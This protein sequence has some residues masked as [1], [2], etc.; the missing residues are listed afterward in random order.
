MQDNKRR[1]VI[2]GGVAAGMKAASRLRRLDPELEITVLERGRRVSY[3]ACALPYYIEGL[4]EELDEVMQTPAGVLRDAEFFRKVKGFEVRPGTEALAVDRAAKR[5]RIRDLASGTESVLPYD[6]L[7]LATGNRPI[8]PPLP[9]IDLAGVHPLKSPEDA[10]QL[11]ELA[12]QARHA[13]IVGG[14]LIGLEMA[15][16]L[17]KRGIAVTLLE[18]KDQVLASALDFGMAALVHRELRKNGVDLRLSEALQ[19]IE[20]EAGKVTRVITAAGSY[21]A[22]L[23]VMAIGVR[24]EVSLAREAGLEIG[25]TGAIA[26]NERLQ[27]SD[28]AI[29]AAGDCAESTDLLSGKK[30]YVP[31]G[32]TANKHGRV[33][34][35]NLCGREERFPGILGSLSVKVF[36]LNVARSGLSE[37]D[38]RL[39]GRDPV[40][41]LASAPDR[42]H[43]YPGAKPVIIK[44]VAE[45]AS[46]RLLGAQ[47]LGSGAVDKRIDTLV[48][49]LTLGASVDQLATMDLAYAPPFASAMDP[50]IQAANVLRNKLD[51]IAASLDPLEV[52]QLRQ[53]NRDALLLDVRSPAEH[54]EIRIPGATLIPLGALRAR[55]A[56]LPRDRQII[57]FCKLSLRG[58]E[59][60][61][62]LQAAGFEKVRFMEGGI[63]AWPF[64]LETGPIR[65]PATP[66][67]AIEQVA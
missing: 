55:L 58:Y 49:A 13:V 16:A 44:L 37:E 34:A 2:V 10:E 39:L 12:Q 28:P 31:L 4:F 50:L 15:E 66:E 1:I 65:E 36:D 67:G 46:R 32:S 54:A 43:I 14:G 3:G 51:G 42:A 6:A 11:M 21:P 53:Q 29:F 25:P 18:M 22:D 20:G 56:E 17:R 48:A 62:I 61:L 38:A 27:T 40:T 47:V 23:V 35:D 26:V 19:R 59:A 63:L 41:V 9:G 33:V 30:V 60:Q 57:P 8:L 64:E 52:Q 45:R 5:V 24:P 7:V